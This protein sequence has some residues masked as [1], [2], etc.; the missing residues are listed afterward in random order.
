METLAGRN[1]VREALVAGR[2]RF[3]RV[4]LAEHVAEQGLI[5]EIQDLCRAAR[6]SVSYVPRHALDRLADELT[7]QGVVAQVS[8][9]L[10]VTM[11]EILDH[12]RAAG[13]DPLL[14]VLDELQDPQNVGALL[15]TA[16]AVGVHGVI[17]GAHRAAQITPAVS[18][19]SA[20]AAEHLLVCAVTNIAKAL[21]SLR[22]MG[23]WIAGIEDLPE[24]QDYRQA[25]LKR[26]LALV[27]GS[28]GQG[29]R[30]LVAKQCDYLL[31]IPM[32]GRINSLN[33]SVAGALVLY[34]ALRYR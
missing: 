19:A 1:S 30:R 34:E 29:L 7:H 27:L 10:Y 3:E 11:D 31:R 16:E 8:P 18:R 26:P 5:R 15:R 20:G 13:G 33:V 6:I 23:L 4:M 21:Q 28:E 17:I 2:R 32:R 22:N 14:L 25:D 9:Y 24:A 12:A